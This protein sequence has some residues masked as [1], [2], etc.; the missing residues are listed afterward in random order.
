RRPVQPSDIARLV[1]V[2][3]PAVSP[4]GRRVAFVVTRFDL[5][6]NRYRSAVWLADADGGSAP[7]PLTAGEHDDGNPTWSPDG[8]RLASPAPWTAA[9]RCVSSPSTGRARR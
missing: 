4:D 2:T 5:D 6:A 1:S 7:Y 9:E 3:S 8:R